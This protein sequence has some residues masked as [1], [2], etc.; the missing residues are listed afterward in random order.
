MS[1]QTIPYD[2]FNQ[3]KVGRLLGVGKW[4]HVY[5]CQD[6]RTSSIYAIK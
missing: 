5:L 6:K 2:A 1:P 3:F 4:A